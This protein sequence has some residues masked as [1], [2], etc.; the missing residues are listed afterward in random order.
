LSIAPGGARS[1]KRAMRV[2][3][4]VDCHGLYLSALGAALAAILTDHHILVARSL[5]CARHNFRPDGKPEL[6]LIDM[7]TPDVSWEILRL[8]RQQ[9]PK[10]RLV[11]M[12]HNSNR[13]DAL[14]ALEIGLSGFI[15][16][17][18][19]DEEI[20]GAVTDV[21][22][23]RIYVPP[24]VIHLDEAESPSVALRAPELNANKLTPR[25]RAI[26]P[27][28]AQGMSNKEIARALKIA[29][30]TTK[31]HASSLLRILGVRNRTEAAVIARNFILDEQGPDSASVEL[32]ENGTRWKR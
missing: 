2:V 13:I 7:T 14:R 22:S 1:G 11:A 31:I 19:S 25:Q 17:S 3:V 9:Y 29:V 12:S 6:A 21:L 27:L 18:Q 28:I 5:A 24:T 32:V 15:S 20:F 4:L 10:T 26:L 23:G 8:L 16:K 30:G